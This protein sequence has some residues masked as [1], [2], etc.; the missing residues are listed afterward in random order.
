M[1]SKICMICRGKLSELTLEI[2][3]SLLL[4]AGLVSDLESLKKGEN[5]AN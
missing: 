2:V 1:Y 4:G 5:G 3:R